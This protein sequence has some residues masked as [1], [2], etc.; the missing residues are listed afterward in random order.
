LEKLGNEQVWLRDFIVNVCALER[1][2]SFKQAPIFISTRLL[3][4]LV[5]HSMD[6]ETDE[7][8]IHKTSDAFYT[9]VNFIKNVRDDDHKLPSDDMAALL[10]KAKSKIA[11]SP[12][13]YE[14]LSEYASSFAFS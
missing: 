8:A 13:F 11:S 10:E 6:M 4:C 5:S 9:L 1:V 3:V 2:L 14:A 12:Y 7:N